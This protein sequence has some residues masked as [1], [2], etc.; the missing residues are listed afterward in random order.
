MISILEILLWNKQA[1]QRNGGLKKT[2]I[3]KSLAK[4][5]VQMRG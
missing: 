3:L 5:L 2:L 4:S 1:P